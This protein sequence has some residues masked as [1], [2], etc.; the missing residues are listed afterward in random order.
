MLNYQTVVINKTMIQITNQTFVY[1]QN[2]FLSQRDW[3]GMIIHHNATWVKDSELSFEFIIIV[4]GL[5]CPILF[6][7]WSYLDPTKCRYSRKHIYVYIKHE[8]L[9][10][11]IIYQKSQKPLI[12]ILDTNDL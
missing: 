3:L 2:R 10:T 5:E 11:Y 6:L 12:I 8:F 9:Y 7:C 1:L 4:G